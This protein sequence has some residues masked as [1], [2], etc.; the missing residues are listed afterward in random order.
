MVSDAAV[1][2]VK[3]LYKCHYT[4]YEVVD[5]LSLAYSQVCDL[6][7]G[8]KYGGVKKHDKLNLLKWEELV[9]A[10]ANNE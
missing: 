9:H 2:K 10:R 6:F 3:E 4:T 8:F 1:E 7:R 5:S